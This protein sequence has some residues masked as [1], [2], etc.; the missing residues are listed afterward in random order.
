ILAE[1][2]VAITPD[3]LR[4]EAVRSTFAGLRVLPTGDGSTTSARRETVYLRGQSGMLSVAGG[5]LT[6]YRRIALTALGM[7]RAEL[8]LHRLDRTPLPLPGAIDPDEGVR[9]IARS[10]PDLDPSVCAHLVHL[11]GS[12]ADEVL[13]YAVADP[14]LLRPLHRE[15]PDLAAQA[16]YARDVEWACRP[17]DVLQRR[18]TLALRGLAGE[19]VVRRVDELL[20]TRA[21]EAPRAAGVPSSPAR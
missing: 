16:V 10:L 18:T 1:A 20:K 7:L 21:G 5:K 19:N 12:L 14:D 13:A 15:G 6:T 11:Y 8:G 9:R 4:R 17:E 3:L 2:A